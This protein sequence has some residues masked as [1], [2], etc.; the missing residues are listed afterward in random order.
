MAVQELPFNATAWALP[1]TNHRVRFVSAN[2][3]SVVEREK[4]A[5]LGLRKGGAPR[6]KPHLRRV[7]Q[8]RCQ[9]GGFEVRRSIQSCAPV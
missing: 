4:A 9:V 6:L 7:R 2:N 5:L 8:R 3:P 1:P